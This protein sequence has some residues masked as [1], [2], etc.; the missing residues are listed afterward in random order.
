VLLLLLFVLAVPGGC[1]QNPTGPAA[2]RVSLSVFGDAVIYAAVNGTPPDRFR[3]VAVEAGT[4]VPATSMQVQWQVVQGSASLT[5]AS[6]ATDGDGV[7]STSVAPAAAGVYRVRATAANITGTAPVIELRVVPAPVIESMEPAVATPGSEI[8]INGANFSG[9]AGEN[10]VY[11]DGIRGTV[12]A[13]TATRLRVV[14][15]SCLPPRQVKV[16]AGLGGVLSTPRTLTTTGVNA[17]MLTLQPGE[18]R[19][20]SGPA[21]LACVRLPGTPFGALYLITPHNA[22]PQTAPPAPFE[23]RALVPGAPAS[24]VPLA[25][26]ARPVPF[27]EGWEAA[28]RRRERDLVRDDAGIA[29]SPITPP[30]VP[31]PSVAAGT[32]RDFN[33]LNTQNTFD[34]VTATATV[35]TQRAVLWVD[36]EAEGVFSLADLQ[37]FGD[38]FD[39][40]IY[41]TNVGV[42][43][44]P[45]DVDG[46]QRIFI[47]F[48][49][50]VNALTPRNESS[51]ITGFFYGCDL[52]TRSR[53]SG[54]NEAEVFYSMVADPGGKW[55]S[56]RTHAVVRAA[57]PPILAHEFQHMIH[58]S[59]RGG[60]SDVLWLSEALAHTAEE[61]VGDVLRAT[62]PVL[63]R[64]FTTANLSR[65]QRYLSA[66]SSSSLLEQ[67][68]TGSVEMRGGAWLLLKHIRGHH[69]GDDL[70]R[71]LTSNQQSGMANLTGQAGQPWD[72][73]VTDMAVAL[74]ADGAPEL[75]SAPLAAR[76]RFVGFN[77]RAELGSVSGGYSLWPTTLGWRDFA[78]T[79]T[80]A[81][82]GSEYLLL[83]TPSTG[84]PLS[85][86]LSG[87][88]GAPFDSGT[89]ARMSILRV[90]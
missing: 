56:P 55:S 59:Q 32:R 26:M 71:R 25:S 64:T 17:T 37:Y 9:V 24:A 33:V 51:Y 16:V 22:S 40:P 36:T 86:V 15:P 75:G 84:E 76:Y 62:N 41:P 60:S 83:A 29:L 6:S 54:S 53:C 72:R 11:F 27:A 49:P 79:G 81:A 87:A 46:N 73:M 67:G 47:L 69:G 7:A 38:L 13:A 90:R 70:L 20:L 66:P 3:V 19:T 89:T 61:L 50:R 82:G 23:L 65:A 52:L 42:F 68:G 85:F 45:S 43:G 4:Q 39:D 44:Q 30:L 18:V 63:A 21:E 31:Q 77:L 8:I 12:L 57:V 5:Q 34:K 80:L 74:W 48:T 35:V 78:V 2:K 1:R 58:F 28:L 10:A 14:V 88:R